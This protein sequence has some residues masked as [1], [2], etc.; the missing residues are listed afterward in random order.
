[1]AVL[2]RLMAGIR[3]NRNRKN[4]KKISEKYLKAFLYNRVEKNLHGKKE[5]DYFS[6]GYR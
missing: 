4:C 5:T 6:K 2:L 3:I 1:M